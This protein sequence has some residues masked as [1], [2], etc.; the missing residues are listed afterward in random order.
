MRLVAAQG[1]QGRWPRHITE[2]LRASCAICKDPTAPSDSRVRGPGGRRNVPLDGL[3]SGSAG[4]LL[5]T[6]RLGLL[7]GEMAMS[8]VSLSIAGTVC[9]DAGGVLRSLELPRAGGSLCLLGLGH[10]QYLGRCAGHDSEQNRQQT[11]PTQSS[12]RPW[13]PGPSLVSPLP[14]S[15]WNR[16]ALKRQGL[17]SGTSQTLPQP[18]S[19]SRARLCLHPFPCTACTLSGHTGAGAAGAPGP[20]HAAARGQPVP[21]APSSVGSSTCTQFQSYPH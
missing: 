3:C 5:A 20:R 9:L 13:H 1:F 16:E 6:P 7:L 8:V 19:S 4:F 10:T 15:A 2:Q 14:L 12:P 18:G 21:Q 17:H 11:G